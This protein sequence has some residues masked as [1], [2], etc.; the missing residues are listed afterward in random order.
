MKYIWRETLSPK[1]S[2]FS[3]P[4]P[5]ATPTGLERNLNPGKG[6]RLSLH[7]VGRRARVSGV[8]VVGPVVF[9]SDWSPGRWISG[10]RA[11]VRDFRVISPADGYS[12]FVSPTCSNPKP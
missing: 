1:P 5:K 11:Q 8:R 10:S 7:A 9:W 2:T 3:A 12:F 6:S 4:G